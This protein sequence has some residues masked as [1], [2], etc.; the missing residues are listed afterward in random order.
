MPFDLGAINFRRTSKAGI[1]FIVHCIRIASLEI[2]PR[3]RATA[4]RFKG[5]GF[6]YCCVEFISSVSITA[7]QRGMSPDPCVLETGKDKGNC[8]IRIA[9]LETF[10]RAAQSDCKKIGCRCY[11]ITAGFST[12][13][14]TWETVVLRKGLSK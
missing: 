7:S 12:E 2:V 14:S 1:T 13:P 5:L 9:W 10:G 4:N 8:G 6:P 11:K 3:L